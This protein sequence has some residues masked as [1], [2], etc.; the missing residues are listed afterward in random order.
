MNQTEIQEMIRRREQ[1]KSEGK[2]ELPL[3]VDPKRYLLNIAVKDLGYLLPLFGLGMLIQYLLWR[4]GYG[5]SPR[6]ILLLLTPCAFFSIALIMK[7]PERKNINF[8]TY[9]G[10][11]R[12]QYNKRVKEFFYFKKGLNDM[13]KAKNKDKK[14][15][16]HHPHEALEIS[17]ITSECFETK[18]KRLVKVIEV[19]HINLSLMTLEKQNLIYDSFSQFLEDLPG[20]MKLQFAHLAQPVNLKQYYQYMTGYRESSD[21]YMSEKQRIAKRGLLDSYLEFTDGL[22]KSQNMVSK[23]AYVIIGSSYSESNK[24]KVIDTLTEDAQALVTSIES[25]I[26][27]ENRLSA[28]VLNND[29]L[30]K[31]IYTCID[32][33]NA[34]ITTDL[35]NGINS[36]LSVGQESGRE[37]I[38]RY[39]KDLKE[40]IR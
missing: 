6:S 17:N 1:L 30:F 9:R 4:W 27:G 37:M 2:L 7:H 14:N 38:E 18:D 19:S 24:E 31:L 39:E 8:L 20:K 28:K 25:M 32:Y 34:Q 22:Q 26:S 33:E 21:N 3:D 35:D 5:I 15:A 23:N 13:G 12:I 11:W 29:E 16:I 36:F 40:K 10:K